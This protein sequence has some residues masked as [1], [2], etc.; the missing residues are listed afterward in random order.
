M[1][2]TG[3]G[4]GHDMDVRRIGN[5]GAVLLGRLLD[6]SGAGLSFDASAHAHLAF[7]DESCAE[8]TR[9]ID[10]YVQETGMNAP[11]DG[12]FGEANK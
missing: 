3:V 12:N 5:D 10:K 2:Y 11:E 9:A 8:F 4:G 1:L 6:C 7:A